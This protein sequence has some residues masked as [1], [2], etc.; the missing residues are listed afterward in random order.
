MFCEIAR[1]LT[2]TFL[3]T[4]C[5]DGFIHHDGYC[6]GYFPQKLNWTQAQAAC[7][8]VGAFLAEPKSLEQEILIEGLILHGAIKEEYIWLGANDMDAEGQWQWA[9]SKEDMDYTNWAPG[10]PDDGGV[11]QD[12]MRYKMTYHHWDDGECRGHAS[13]ICQEPYVTHIIG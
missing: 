7:N 13:F 8:A 2:T 10:Q 4:D 9:T 1:N 12:C 3:L 6:F 5:S 11:S